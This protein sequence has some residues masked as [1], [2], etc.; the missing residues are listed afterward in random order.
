MFSGKTLDDRAGICAIITVMKNLM[1]IKTE[2]DVYAVCAVSEETGCRGA[3]VAAYHVQ[4]DV[5]IA[6]DVCHGI[7]PDNSNNAFECG[8]G[9]V[10]SVG[11]NLHPKV[12]DKLFEIA[13]NHNIKTETDVDGGCTGTDA[14]V[15]QVSREGVPTGLLS[16]PL[17]YMHTSVETLDIND[18]KATADLLTCFIAESGKTEDWLCY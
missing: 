17:K 8:C 7:T 10:I 15:I 18:V 13:E 3:K 12:C 4:P 1:R 6:I 9:T 11:P 16:I 14:W 5:A 2:N